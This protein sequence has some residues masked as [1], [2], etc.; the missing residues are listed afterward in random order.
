MQHREK[1]AT[2]ESYKRLLES[3]YFPDMHAREEGIDE[4]HKHT[5]EWIFEKP[6]NEVRPW[7]HFIGWLEEGHG[8]YWISGKAGS[9]KSTLMNFVCHDSRTEAAL[10]IWSGTC[11]IFT[12]NFFFWSPGSQLQKSLAGLLRSLIYQMLERFPDLMPILA[13]SIGPCQHGLRQLPAWTEQRLCATLQ[14]LFSVGLAQCRL[15]IFIDGLDEFHGDHVTLLNLISK[16]REITRVKFCLSSRPYSPFKHEL[17]SSPMLKLQDLTEPDIRRYVADKL[18]GAPLKASWVPYSSS[19]IEHLVDTIVQKAEGVFLWVRLAVRDQLEGIRNGDDAKQLR[20]R[21]QILPTEIEEVYS[22]MLHG[23]D[24]VYRKEVAQYVRLVL[25][26]KH[27]WSL[28]EIAL[29]EHKR[30]DDILLFSEEISIRDVCQHC[31]SV[32]ERLAAT[33]K[34]FIEVRV[35]EANEELQRDDAQMFSKSLEDRNI[36]PEQREELR[37]MK[38]LQYS[39]RVEFLHRTAFDFFNDNEQG[40]EFLKI[41][42]IVNTHPQVLYVKALLAHLRIL[43]VSKDNT[44]LQYSIESIMRNASVAEEAT[45]V[46]Q[47]VLMELI[48]RCITLLWEH[49]PGK[50]SNLPWYRTWVKPLDYP[51]SE[52]EIFRPRAKVLRA[53]RPVNYQLSIPQRADFLGLAARYGLDKYIQHMLDLQSRKWESGTADYLLRCSAGGLLD[54]R[55]E[56][57]H[58][59][60]IAALLKRGADPNMGFLEGTLWGLFLYRLHSHSL[61]TYK[62]NFIYIEDW[63]FFELIKYWSNTAKAFL[64]S[65]ANVHENIYSIFF[66]YKSIEGEA[67]SEISPHFRMAAYGIEFC[68]STRSVM[69]WAFAKEPDFFKIEDLLIASGA[70]LH[71]ECTHLMCEVVKGEVKKWVVLEPSEQQLHQL[72]SICE[73]G[74]LQRSTL[75]RLVHETIQNTDMDQLFEQAPTVE[76]LENN[77]NS[78]STNDSSSIAAPASPTDEAEGSFYSAHSSQQEE[79]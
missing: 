41:H 13:E 34:G 16:F 49:S 67:I 57:P 66:D 63:R 15:C 30:I 55:A 65:G 47:P 17:S 3:L 19:K 43:P 10:K 11:D 70:T 29:A 2:E 12:P 76:V 18:E 69:Q 4:A 77:T 38:S 5:F 37:E 51:F 42:T 56:P 40:K 78:K 9:G 25:D 36:P 28:S 6:G 59:K 32:G 75:D 33:C 31:K 53:T 79:D 7:H 52:K 73:Q 71:L 74:L 20:E 21:L 1:I 44:D 24:K 58:L 48:D 50:P 62:E 72:I 64:E 39:T 22:H 46:A 54:D 60:L 27:G 23:I 45:G 8:T 14:N 26:V 68:L 61:F 35:W